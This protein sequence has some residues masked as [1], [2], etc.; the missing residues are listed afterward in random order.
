MRYCASGSSLE[1]TTVI[2]K[3]KQSGRFSRRMVRCH[4]RKKRN[5]TSG[6]WLFAVAV[7]IILLSNRGFALTR[8]SAVQYVPD[9]DMLEGGTF[10]LNV[11]GYYYSDVV[12]GGK[13]RPIGTVNVG[14]IEWVNIEAGYTGGFSLGVKARIL[15][16]TRPWMPSLA[17]G[18]HNLFSHRESYLYDRQ[19]DSL[20][21]ELYLVFGKSIE[22]IRLR[23]H[24]G[25]QMIPGNQDELFNPFFVIEK[26]FGMNLYVTAEVHRREKMMHPSLFA[27][28]RFWKRRLEVSA[29][30]VDIAGMFMKDDVPP[31]SPFFKS[32]NASFVRPGI[33]VGLRFKGGLKFGKTDGL[34]GVEN[35]LYSH[36]TS[37]KEMRGE[38]DS[39]K[40]LIEKSSLRIESMD[41]S[42]TG[43]A[44]S[45]LTDTQRLKELAVNRLAVLD[46][47]YT[48]EPF[49]PEA[50]NKEMAE[51]IA[52][53]DRMLPA[54]YEVI[55]DP[56]Q[57]TA[58]RSLAI[59]ALGE[60]GTQAAADIII[61]VLGK[62]PN[63]E[64]A[65]ECLIALG[66]MKETR[67]V[68]LIQQLSNDPNDD[69]AFTAAEVLQKL[70]KETGV[71][72]T[73]IPAAMLAPESIPEKKIGSGETYT[74][75]NAPA[76]A[77]TA[78]APPV[79]KHVPEP[80]APEKREGDMVKAEQAEFMEAT[81]AD[82]PAA[83]ETLPETATKSLKSGLSSPQKEEKA[84]VKTPEHDTAVLPP[85][86]AET[87]VV[88][89]PSPPAVKTAP[90][91]PARKTAQE[92]ASVKKTDSTVPTTS[93]AKTGE[94]RQDTK[95]E[96]KPE[97]KRTPRRERP[98]IDLSKETW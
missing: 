54:L 49:E 35:S 89:E 82:E 80:I 12:Y 81:V 7:L 71:S 19:K 77:R 34:N 98:K 41:R 36:S 25:M 8:W 92:S 58:I 13:L 53:R 4:K 40:K 28:W 5:D 62:S 22:P 59:T 76:A 30:L 48:A 97:K 55:F 88:Q 46:N 70:E 10:V 85:K 95:K 47:L 67:A 57:K 78:A 73:P 21:N 44:D 64:M 61:E 27:S 38:I 56:V 69:V 45:S 90:E 26:Y 91:V 43:L 2:L 74:Q 1:Q 68:Y 86:A 65:I 63:P 32:T 83:A 37:I 87:P 72:V 94:K 96:Q 11:H 79:R 24:V 84:A 51:L 18:I 16:E 50:V 15:G 33:W 39:L 23:M 3:G 52:N 31:N 66:K 14:I 6:R 75:K 60:I 9:A 17:I 42:L 29:G 93:D 20:G